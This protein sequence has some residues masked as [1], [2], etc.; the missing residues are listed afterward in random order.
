MP[1][2]SKN[3]PPKRTVV[4]RKFFGANGAVGHKFKRPEL[5]VYFVPEKIANANK[6]V[7]DPAEVVEENFKKNCPPSI[8]YKNKWCFLV[9]KL[10]KDLLLFCHL[11]SK[12]LKHF[13]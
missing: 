9:E 1:K 12:N 2:K 5:R 7:V 10:H 8:Y 13:G 4:I 11:I 3:S 6:A